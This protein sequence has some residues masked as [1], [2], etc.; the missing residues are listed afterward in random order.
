MSE[1]GDDNMNIHREGEEVVFNFQLRLRLS[2]EEAAY[3]L[4][5]A[6]LRKIKRQQLLRRL[7]QA[8]LQDRLITAV[9]DDL[10]KPLNRIPFS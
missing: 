5:S 9:L 8:V 6:R 3:L 4:S 7:M 1:A 10:S 2:E